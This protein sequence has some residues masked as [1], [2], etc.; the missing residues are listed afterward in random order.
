MTS[1]NTCNGTLTMHTCSCL[2]LA[3]L[4]TGPASS[5]NGITL[6]TPNIP[7]IMSDSRNCRR[8]RVRRFVNHGAVNG[9]FRVVRGSVA[10]TVRVLRNC[11]HPGGGCVGRSMT[12]KVTTHCCLLTRG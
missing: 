7:V 8:A 1:H 4:F 10:G 11:R 9:I 5:L 2:C 6:R 12:R 3:R